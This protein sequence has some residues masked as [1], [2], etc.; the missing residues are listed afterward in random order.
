MACLCQVQ[1]LIRGP[2]A[3]KVTIEA[4]ALS[5]EVYQ[6]AKETYTVDLVRGECSRQPT[7]PESLQPAMTMS[8]CVGSQL[9]SPQES[10]KDKGVK[11][12]QA[13]ASVHGH[14]SNGTQTSL[15]QKTVDSASAEGA[16][17]AM[18]MKLESDVAALQLERGLQEQNL[19]AMEAQL[20]ETPH[21]SDEILREKHTE[22][23]QVS[24]S[25]FLLAYRTAVSYMHTN[26]DGT[27]NGYSEKGVG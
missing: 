18:V 5:A 11:K 9:N 22:L 8:V 21:R 1:D 6:R 25:R 13:D 7:C 17:K 23:L 27:R 12:H 26:A 19:I 14:R 3:T 2:P 4:S 16:L 15:N 10:E 24:K 20:K